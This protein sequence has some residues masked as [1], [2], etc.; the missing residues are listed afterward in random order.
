MRSIY[1]SI[2]KR[3]LKLADAVSFGMGTPTNILF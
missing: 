2:N 1:E 3:F